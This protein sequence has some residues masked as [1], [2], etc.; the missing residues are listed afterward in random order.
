MSD[1]DAIDGKLLAALQEDNQRSNADLARLVDLSP[2][3]VHK[4]VRKLR[5]QGYVARDVA[6]LDRKRLGIDLLAFLQVRFRE[7]MKPENNVVL[8]AALADLP[9]VLECYTLTGSDDAILKIAVR[10]QDSLKEFMQRLAER[11][12]VIEKAHTAI[13]LEEIKSTTELPLAETEEDA[14]P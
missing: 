13:V 7:N 5:E 2:A 9:E 4:R 6:L 3:G 1:L 11:Q 14:S 10:N 8:R 12:D